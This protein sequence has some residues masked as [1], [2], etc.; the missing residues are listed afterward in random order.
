MP[1]I[2]PIIAAPSG[3]TAA[4]PA[5]IATSP[6]SAPFKDNPK[7][8]LLNLA[9]ATNMAPTAPAAAARL[10]VTKT[11]AIARALPVPEAANCE[12]GLNPNQPNQRINTPNVPSVRLWPGIAFGFPFTNFPIRGPRVAAP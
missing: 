1:A 3:E 12:P 9:Q 4:Q 5:V 8:G 6:A 11:C 7:L 2:R 10:V